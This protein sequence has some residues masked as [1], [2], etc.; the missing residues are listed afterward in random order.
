MVAER[1]SERRRNCNKAVEQD[2]EE[3][4]Q[5]DGE[6]NNVGIEE[7]DMYS[8]VKRKRTRRSIYDSTLLNR[9]RNEE[10]KCI[11]RQGKHSDNS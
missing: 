8:R 2:G 10:R 9:R 6:Q 11:Q 7:M 1:K 3:E 5:H 4:Q